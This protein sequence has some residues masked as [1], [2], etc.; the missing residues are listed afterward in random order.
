VSNKVSNSSLARVLFAVFLQWWLTLFQKRQTKRRKGGRQGNVK[1]TVTVQQTRFPFLFREGV[2]FFLSNNEHGHLCNAIFRSGK[3]LFNNVQRRIKPFQHGFTVL[4][5]FGILFVAD[6]TCYC[7]R[8]KTH[9][10]V[11]VLTSVSNSS[12][13][14]KHGQQ[15]TQNTYICRWS[16]ETQNYTL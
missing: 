14:F 1:T 10:H 8:K 11:S 6:I 9:P 13:G 15:A 5:H 2:C 3:T 7:R 12:A 16:R 4:H